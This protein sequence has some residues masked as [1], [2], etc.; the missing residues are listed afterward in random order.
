[1]RRGEGRGTL[2]GMNSELPSTLWTANGR[3]AN[4][5]SVRQL[6]GED[7]HLFETGLR[8]GAA[9]VALLRHDGLLSDPHVEAP[10]PKM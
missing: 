10:S 8:A 4:G 5:T 2:A 7:R 1:M 9:V 3:A 6:D